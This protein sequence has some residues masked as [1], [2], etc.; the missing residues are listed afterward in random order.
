MAYLLPSPP[1]ESCSVYCANTNR[2][3]FMG[4]GA[5]VNGDVETKLTPVCALEYQLETYLNHS[6]LGKRE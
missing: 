3:V 5:K 2:C 6:L 4:N 1:L